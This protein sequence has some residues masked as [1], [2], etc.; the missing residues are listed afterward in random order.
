MVDRA[1]SDLEWRGCGQ[2]ERQR[3]P[4]HTFD[5]VQET[6]SD[7][8]ALAA[9]P[10]FRAGLRQL[11][12]EHLESLPAPAYIVAENFDIAIAVYGPP[13]SLNVRREYVQGPLPSHQ[14]LHGSQHTRHHARR[15]LQQSYPLQ[16]LPIRVS[17]HQVCPPLPLEQQH[18][19]F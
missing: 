4:A 15:L 6:V 2:R 3:E 10:A 13:F 8:E 18:P 7:I 17:I 1:M 5:L 9:K 16:A 11:V 19:A 14:E 12:V